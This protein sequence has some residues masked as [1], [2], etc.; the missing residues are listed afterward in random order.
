MAGEL[1]DVYRSIAAAACAPFFW[2]RPFEDNLVIL[3]SG[4]L[5]LVKTP[6]LPLIGITAAHVIRQLE[7]DASDRAVKLQVM[8]ALIE[9][10]SIIA[11]SDRLDIATLQLGEDA[12]QKLGKPSTPVNI[13]R[14]QSPSEGRGIMLAGYPGIERVTR[15]PR[16]V[17][18]GLFTALGIS[19]RVT[20][21]Q[22]T[23]VPDRENN[24][25]HFPMPPPGYN[26][27]G[28][29]GGPLI[30]WFESP[31]ML[32][33]FG[34]VGIVSQASAELENIVCKRTDFIRDDGTIQNLS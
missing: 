20:D 5:T 34:L 23:W 17:D 22:I 28:I 24:V 21:E 1:G 10:Y 19:R 2:Y 27:G 15:H 16:D 9:D 13:W 30:G 14:G 4:T 11:I 26:T 32:A 6:E 29:S 3:H 8:N 25:G 12:L 18:F 31:R 33:T 7:A